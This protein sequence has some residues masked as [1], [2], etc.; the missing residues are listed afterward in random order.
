MVLRFADTEPPTCCP[1][2]PTCDEPSGYTPSGSFLVELPQGIESFTDTNENVW[3]LRPFET[4]DITNGYHTVLCR[5]EIEGEWS[6]YSATGTDIEWK[7]EGGAWSQEQ[8]EPPFAAGSEQSL[9]FEGGVKLDWPGG[10]QGWSVE[11]GQGNQAIELPAIYK[12][13]FRPDGDSEAEYKII[14]SFKLMRMDTILG[15]NAPSVVEHGERILITGIQALDSTRGLPIKYIREDNQGVMPVATLKVLYNGNV[16][17]GPV[18]IPVSGGPTEH[19]IDAYTLDAKPGEY[20]IKLEFSPPTSGSSDE[21]Y[22]SSS[23]VKTLTV[24]EEPTTIEDYDVTPNVARVDE[25]FSV[26]GRVTDDNGNPPTSGEA[27]LYLFN[28]SA[29]TFEE[30]TRQPIASDGGFSFPDSVTADDA[31]RQYRFQVEYTDPNNNYKESAAEDTVGARRWDTNIQN[32]TTKPVQPSAIDQ[33]RY[34]ANITDEDGNPLSR[35]VFLR[36]DDEKIAEVTPDGDGNLNHQ[37]P[38]E[39]VGTHVATYQFPQS[40]EYAASTASIEISVSKAPTETRVD[41]VPQ[42]PYP[43]QEVSIQGQVTTSKGQPISGEPADIIVDGEV[44]TSSS[45]SGDGS[46]HHAVAWDMEGQHSIQ[47]TFKGTPRYRSSE[48]GL[49]KV[50]VSKENKPTVETVTTIDAVIPEDTTHVEGAARLETAD[51]VAIVDAPLRVFVDG[52]PVREMPTDANGEVVFVFEDISAGKHTLRATFAGMEHQDTV[53]TASSSDTIMMDVPGVQPPA[54]L[55]D[56]LPEGVDPWMA[57]AAGG[58][59]ILLLAAVSG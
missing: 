38:A 2:L 5:P 39:S 34:L 10:F 13:K 46:V 6:E 12:L 41:V 47:V 26:S 53:Y 50:D 52:E 44:V 32:F 55:V 35:K 21:Y 3:R 31:D 28:P 51:G 16:V 4:F 54:A 37:G 56:I 25:T 11:D 33:I 23:L 19:A 1:N 17:Y 36:V 43:E 27:I 58:G 7:K 57:V 18:T 8:T 30:I 20:T 29:E 14:E 49:V 59:I 48:S 40:R 15:M 45:T 24:N 22:S 42:N 9:S